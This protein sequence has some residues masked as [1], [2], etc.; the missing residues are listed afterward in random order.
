MIHPDTASML[1]ESLPEYLLVAEHCVAF[2][3]DPALGLGRGCLGYPAAA[4]MFSIVDAIG[5]YYEDDSSFTMEVDG[6]A[7]HIGG[8]GFQHFFILNS[9]YYGQSLTERE[10][11]RLYD[12]YRNLLLHNSALALD[13]FLTTEPDNPKAFLQWD[14]GYVV[15]V[16]GFLSITRG[17]VAAFLP[18]LSEVVPAS[19]QGRIIGL[20]K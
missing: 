8:A 6:S 3:K 19:K 10:I 20:K 4:L 2:R 17:A 16:D 12:N 1:A 14:P 9:E 18:R 5:S 7:R 13:H 15:N 11:K